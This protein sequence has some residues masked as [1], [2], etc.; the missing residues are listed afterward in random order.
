MRRG[1]GLTVRTNNDG[2]RQIYPLAGKS[3]RRAVLCS[4]GFV[5]LAP[6]V[7][8]LGSSFPAALHVPSRRGDKLALTTCGCT[9]LPAVPTLAQVAVA[10]MWAAVQLRCSQSPLCRNEYGTQLCRSVDD[11]GRI[12]PGVS[13]SVEWI[14]ILECLFSKLTSRFLH[15]S[16]RFLFASIRTILA[17]LHCRHKQVKCNSKDP[18]PLA[19]V[20]F[21]T[22]L[23]YYQPNRH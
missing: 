8:G 6:H 9:V 3:E 2:S 14:Y 12:A 19:T 23:V 11:L 20:S 21:C 17:C 4:E 15:F 22:C 1:S 16:V 18:V 7:L 5:E 13:F 10:R